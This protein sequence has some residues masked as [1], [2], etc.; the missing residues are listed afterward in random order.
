MII[1]E[2][3]LKEFILDSGLVSRADFTKAEKEAKDTGVSVGK[4][5]VS[6]GSVK[7]DDLRRMQAYILSFQSLLLGITIL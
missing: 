5:L 3:Q 1:D 4:V 6:E 2:K 7:E